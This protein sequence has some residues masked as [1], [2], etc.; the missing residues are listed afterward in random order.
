MARALRSVRSSAPPAVATPIRCAIYTRKSTDEG[1]DKDFNS[2]DN[3]REA[4]ENYISSQRHEG[5]ELLPDRYDDG[6]FTGGNLARPSLQR[7]L[8]DIESRKVD[9][10][11]VYKID[12]LSR[13]LLD[14]AKLADFLEKHDC[15]IVAVTQQLDTAT[16]MGRLTLNMLLSFAQFEREMVSDRTRDKISAA[17]RK[18]KW[19]GGTPRLGYDVAPEGGSLIVNR[20]EAEHVRAI[21]R[22]Y[23]E[24]PSLVAVSQELNRR[25]LRRKS[26]TT[27]DGRRRE[28]GA[29]DVANLR[30][31]LS[32]PTYTGKV[33][34]NGD[35]YP[36]EHEGIVPKT[37]FDKVQTSVRENRR[38]GGAS[39][40][41][42]HGALLRGL[43]R[44][45][46]CDA[47]MVHT[48]AKNGSRLYRYYTCSRAQKRGATTCPTRS[49]CAEEIESFVVDLIRV[50]GRDADVRRATFKQALAHVAGQR[51]ALKV[52][53]KRLSADLAGARIQVDRLVT[54][55]S[56]A[57]GDASQALL[58][59]LSKS[60]ERLRALEDRLREVRDQQAQLDA[61]QVDENDLA[62]ALE[63][64]DPIWEVLLT[65]EKERI[66]G[67]LIDRIDYHGEHGTLS[68]AFRLP[69]IATLAAETAEK[70]S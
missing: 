29:W 33:R 49:V 54:A 1:L 64:F 66:L 4:A 52:E 34:L 38:T 19:T 18:G 63:Q 47:A 55:V 11:V 3:Q 57:S 13:S 32:D 8:A 14:F 37:L 12:R 69:G 20:E 27:R 16:S 45:K 59:G 39:R 9:R 17:R 15:S 22:L 65:P 48:W 68:I 58:E 42:T 10:V 43:L 28:G 56:R 44:C 31:F 2:L 60:Q 26:W 61:V 70:A 46:A 40:R 21:F 51:R 6:G 50:I 67:L 62:R 30:R 35:V 5:W 53:A 23:A 24:N 25:G 7:M 36:G 41:N